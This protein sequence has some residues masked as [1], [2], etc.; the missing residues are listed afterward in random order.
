MKGKVCLITGANRGIGKATALG[1]AH[2]GADVVMVCRNRELGEAARA[3][4]AEI[5]GSQA[6]SPLVADLASQ[7]AVQRL[8]DTFIGTRQ[9]LHVLINNAGVTK[10]YLTLTKDGLETTFAVNH[11]APFLLTNLLLDTLK[12]NVPARI[13]N[14]ASM[15]H[16]WGRIRF[17]DLMGQRHYSMDRAYSQS[18][19]ANILFTYELARRLDGTGIVANCLDPGMV[20]SDFAREYTGFKRLM[21]YKLWRPFMRSLEKGAETVIYLASSPDLDGVTGKYFANRRVVRSSRASHDPALAKQ[22]WE[23]SEKLTNLEH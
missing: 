12:N 6:I 19:L 10:R 9:P 5:T 23:V 22:L 18:K 1:L 11:L 4:I 7:Q 15:V 8:V 14:V 21:A 17:D 16:R 3:E 2:M 13:V 20:A